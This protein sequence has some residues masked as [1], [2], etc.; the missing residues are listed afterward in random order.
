MSSA[1]NKVLPLDEIDSINA[2][3]KCNIASYVIILTYKHMSKRDQ[4]VIRN[5]MTYRETFVYK[6]KT[7]GNKTEPYYESEDDMEI[8]IYDLKKLCPAEK[9]IVKLLKAKK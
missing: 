7:L 3:L 9:D 1:I 2:R 5:Y 6:N 4:E 8:P